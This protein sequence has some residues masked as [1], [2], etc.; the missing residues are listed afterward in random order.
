MSTPAATG[1]RQ[2]GVCQQEQPEAVAKAYTAALLPT[3]P[4]EGE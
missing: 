2:G 4:G 1:A 3:W